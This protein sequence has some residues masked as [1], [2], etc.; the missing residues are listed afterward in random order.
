MGSSASSVTKIYVSEST[1]SSPVPNP[2]QEP[3]PHTTTSKDSNLQDHSQEESKD[4]N[5]QDHSQEE[6]NKE[7]KSPKVQ[8]QEQEQDSQAQQDPTPSPP[9]PPEPVTHPHV[10]CDG[11]GQSPLRGIRFH[12]IGENYDLNEAEFSKLDEGQKTQFEL[13]LYPGAQPI[14][15]EPVVHYNIVCDASN[16]TPIF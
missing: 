7:T 14:R 13:I 2:S 9:P 5:P 16:V 12:K 15:W 4:S 1:S 8:Q 3:I 10:E 11:S 6:S